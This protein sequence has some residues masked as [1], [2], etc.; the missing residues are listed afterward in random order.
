MNDRLAVNEQNK[1]EE[2]SMPGVLP[3]SLAVKYSAIFFSYIFHPLFIPVYIT[4]F[5][6]FLHP[7]AFAGLDDWSKLGNLLQ[8]FVN[9][10]FL[11]IVSILLLKGLK[12]I[13]SVYLKTQR[14][15]IVPYMIC[16]IF[17]F[18][19]WYAFKNSHGVNEMVDLSLAIFIASILG[20]L[21]NIS[22]KI[23][24]HTIAA[25]VMCAFMVLLAFDDSINLILYLSISF[26]IAG[27]VCTSRLIISDH[28]VLEIYAGLFI[29]ILS[30][31]SA[32]Y[33]VGA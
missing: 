11:P 9:C 23:S 1:L 2:I 7:Y 16:M 30:Q 21:A 20:F 17:Y 31:V 15:R 13:D 28:S 10:T 8:V 24:M 32:H 4:L 33:F 19:N 3:H 26:L 27:V 12:F 22:I 14:E 6:V 18:W 5:L 25:G 29:G